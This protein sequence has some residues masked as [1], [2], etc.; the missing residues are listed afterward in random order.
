VIVDGTW[1]LTP[2]G[3]SELVDSV[4]GVPVSVESDVIVRGP[5]GTRQVIV[6]AGTT[7]LSGAQ[8]AAYAT[9]IPEGA[10]EQVRLA[11]Y[12]EVLQ[13]LLPRLTGD[14]ATL[15]KQLERLGSQS[16]VTTDDAW[17]ATYLISMGEGIKQDDVLSQTLPVKPIDVGGAVSAY[18]L[19]DAET[20]A[21]V[22]QQFAG[23]LPPGG[24]DRVRVLVENG[25]G[26]AGLVDTAAVQLTNGGFAFVNGGNANR[27]GYDKS[28]VIVP[29][30]STESTQL[31]T[32]VAKALGL[33]AS[34]V[35]ISA[36]GQT[37]ADVVVILGAD[38]TS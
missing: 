23:S 1:T 22:D 2:A 6:P 18:S 19:D 38:Y 26:S 28:V 4:G 7:R 21:L 25:V 17:L 36:Q 29:D 30:S 13:A 12:D 15:Q 31:G 20:Q 37:V 11:H 35:R 10:D 14:P 8:A 33:P 5:G 34:A 32:E 24:N 9:S 16:V 27:F 3:L